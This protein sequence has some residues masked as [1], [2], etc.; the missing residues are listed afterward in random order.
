MADIALEL[1]HVHK[2]FGRT[3]VLRDVSLVV[4]E[5]ERVALIGPNGAGKSTLFGVASGALAPDSGEVRLRGERID[6]RLPYDIRRRGLARSFQAS[7]LFG[8]L[9]V[10][11]NVRCALLAAQG[12]RHCF[13]RRLD[14]LDDVNEQALQVLARLHLDQRCGVPAAQ[15]AYAE[16]RA[17]DVAIALAGTAHTVLLDEPTAGMS[18]SETQRFVQV[19][20]EATRGRT[21]IVVEHD[22]GVVQELADRVAVLCGGELLVDGRPEA[23]RADARVQQAYLGTASLA[24]GAAPGKAR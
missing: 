6:G 12:R 24:A 11:D 13:W 22:M 8:R 19:L 3:A 18:R 2:R 14:R 20:R 7:R 16:Q 10:L 1:R 15:L 17:L 23:V 9:S 21:L 4:R 5:G